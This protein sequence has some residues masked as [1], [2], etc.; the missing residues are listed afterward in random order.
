L[1]TLILLILSTAATAMYATAKPYIL[2]NDGDPLSYFRKAW[3]LLGRPEGLD[4]AS[5]G[6]G[7][8]LWLIL[9]GA[10]SFDSWWGLI[11]SHLAMAIAAPLI[12]YAALRRFSRNGAFAAA[13]LL[14]ASGLPWQYMNWVM[15]EHLFLF[16]ELLGLWALA[17]VIQPD[18][19]AAP[20]GPDA[21][22]GAA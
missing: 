6:P 5:R 9:T 22:I 2:Y 10:A 1:R 8:P 20:F 4:V 3:L 15:T 11:A 14:M 19:Q 17:A 13:L 7:Y 12:V 21:P 16:V 18:I